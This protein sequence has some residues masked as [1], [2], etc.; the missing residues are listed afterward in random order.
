MRK[1]ILSAVF[2]LGLIVALAGQGAVMP[3]IETVLK[4]PEAELII[5][6]IPFSTYTRIPVTPEYIKKNY[7]F[8]LECKGESLVE[9][10]P[11]L[12][13]VLKENTKKVPKDIRILIEILIGDKEELILSIEDEALAMKM[14]NRIGESGRKILGL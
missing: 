9:V 4:N 5:Y 2:F 13:E 10:V 12:V 14:L 8:R 3:N 6:C 7:A 11:L 1:I